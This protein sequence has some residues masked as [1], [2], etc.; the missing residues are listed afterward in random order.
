[1]LLLP[2]HFCRAKSD[3]VVNAETSSFV[4]CVSGIYLAVATDKDR[5]CPGGVS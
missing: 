3:D 2:L 4:L 1:M 5:L